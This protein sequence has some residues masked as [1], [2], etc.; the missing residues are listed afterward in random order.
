MIVCDVWGKTVKLQSEY[1]IVA[2]VFTYAD[3]AA[4]FVYTSV[5][6]C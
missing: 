3:A 5:G 2:N 6:H 4:L 1:M